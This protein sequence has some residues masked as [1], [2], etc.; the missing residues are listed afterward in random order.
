MTNFDCLLNT[1]SCSLFSVYDYG[2]FTF[3]LCYCG[4]KFMKMGNS[5]AAAVWL[6]CLM[7]FGHQVEA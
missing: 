1:K 4:T 7:F 5:S 6:K 2:I 3:C